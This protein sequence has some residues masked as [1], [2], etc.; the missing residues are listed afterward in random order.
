M[1]ILLSALLLSALLVACPLRNPVP[2]EPD[3]PDSTAAG[4]CEA[5]CK[6]LSELGCPEGRN[7]ESGASCVNVCGTAGR[8]RKLPTSCWA[9]AKS[10][11]EARACGALRCES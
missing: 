8:L 5:A 1:K 9:N 7:S 11:E 6:R 10:K 2:V 4:S 3:Y